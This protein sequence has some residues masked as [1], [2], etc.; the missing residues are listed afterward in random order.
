MTFKNVKYHWVETKSD[1]KCVYDFAM[2]FETT[3]KVKI[4]DK[5]QS[6]TLATVEIKPV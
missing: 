2:W 5:P 3:H 4:S 6:K 1:I